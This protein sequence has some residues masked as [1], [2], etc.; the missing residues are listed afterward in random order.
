FSNKTRSEGMF[1]RIHSLIFWILSI[2]K[3]SPLVA[4]DL[5]LDRE[6]LAGVRQVHA[7]EGLVLFQKVVDR[8]QIPLVQH[9]LERENFFV[10]LQLVHVD[11]HG[12]GEGLAEHQQIV[13]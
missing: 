12:S 13:Q 2:F 3:S 9:A 10:E 6:T 8:L 4:G 7:R 5:A 1:S 11:L